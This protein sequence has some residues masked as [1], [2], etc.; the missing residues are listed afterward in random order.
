MNF[1][2]VVVKILIVLMTIVRQTY[3][4]RWFFTFTSCDKQSLVIIGIL[5]IGFAVGH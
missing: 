4:T 2:Y 5:Y 1:F 3:V